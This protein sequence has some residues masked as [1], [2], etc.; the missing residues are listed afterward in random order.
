MQKEITYGN[1][2]MEKMLNGNVRGSRETRE[3]ES[4][5]ENYFTRR[6]ID[7]PR[8]RAF[9]V[10]D[11]SERFVHVHLVD[12]LKLE[13]EKKDVMEYWKSKL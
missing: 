13:R 1:M 2:G 11:H 10:S 5:Y 7:G 9:D 3:R 12:L 6:D 4:T 8:W